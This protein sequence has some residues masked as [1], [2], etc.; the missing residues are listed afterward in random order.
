MP[1][2]PFSRLQET[3]RAGAELRRE[4]A[5]MARRSRTELAETSAAT[6]KAIFDSRE[7]MAKI[8]AI[9]AKWERAVPAAMAKKLE[10]PAP[11]SWDVY[12]V[13]KKAI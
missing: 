10:P 9:V 7:L 5:D 3:V 2:F 11:P 8:D 13:A 12:K 4:L 6:Q 1:R